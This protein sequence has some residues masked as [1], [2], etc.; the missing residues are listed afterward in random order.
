MV[1][2]PDDVPV[3]AFDDEGSLVGGPISTAGTTGC[4]SAPEALEERL[5][6]SFR[7]GLRDS[8]PRALPNL[9][10]RRSDRRLCNNRA[11]R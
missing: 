4:A 9:L 7:W 3:A 1:P 10:D 5:S 6:G 11:F 8:P 2:G